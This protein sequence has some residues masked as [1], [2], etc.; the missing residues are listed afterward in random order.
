MKKFIL[1]LASAALLAPI[2]ACDDDD[3]PNIKKERVE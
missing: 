2:T 3:E 1:Y